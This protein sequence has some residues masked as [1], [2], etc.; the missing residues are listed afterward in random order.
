MFWWWCRKVKK[1]LG[2]EISREYF[3]EYYEAGYT[4]EGAVRAV[5]EIH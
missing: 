2:A 5:L 4:P 3:R 1:I